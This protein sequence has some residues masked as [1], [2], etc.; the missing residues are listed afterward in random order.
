VRG[1]AVTL[2]V[3][4]VTTLFTATAL[5]RLMVA[6]WLRRRRPAMLPV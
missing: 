1:F 6:T 3:G 4:I 2:G 5:S